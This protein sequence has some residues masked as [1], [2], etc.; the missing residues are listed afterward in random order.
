MENAAKPAVEDL[1]VRVWGM[2]AKGKPFSQSAYARNLT[3]DGA[4]LSGVDDALT[5]GDTIGVQHQD[6]KARFTVVTTRNAGLP[7]KT[8]VELRLVKGQ[9]CPWAAQIPSKPVTRGILTPR[10]NSKRRFERLPVPFPIEIRDHRSG[11]GMQTNA[12][13]ISGRGCYVESQ[14]PLSLGTPLTIIFWIDSDKIITPAVV[15]TCDPGVGMG[16]EF[17]GLSPQDQG[18]VQQAVERAFTS[19]RGF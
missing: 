5:P 18:R 16:I 11:T 4:M 6:K 9:E 15:R 8:Q 7:D 1:V 12:S 2:N 10:I 14:A 13:D 17:I 3:L 19:S